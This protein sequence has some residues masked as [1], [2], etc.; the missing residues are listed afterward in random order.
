M[1]SNFEKKIRQLRLWQF[2][3]RGLALNPQVLQSNIIEY[4]I[5]NQLGSRKSVLAILSNLLELKMIKEIELPPEKPGRPKK[6]YTRPKSE[7]EPILINLG[8]LPESFHLYI[9]EEAESQQL[10]KNEI[11]IQ[12]LKWTFVQYLEGIQKQDKPLEKLPSHLEESPFKTKY[13][14]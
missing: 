7:E 13:D 14:L 10:G 12:L 4:A 8:A 3:D 2:V 6:A 11:V 5:Q 1:I 9:N